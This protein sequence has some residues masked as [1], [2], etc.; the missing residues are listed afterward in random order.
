LTVING[1]VIDLSTLTL[2][3]HTLTVN[4]IDKA[5]NSATK[6]VT[7]NLVGIVPAIVDINPDTL[8]KASKGGAVTT[9]IEITGYDVN[10][11]DVSTVKLRTNKGIVSAQST[12]TSVGDYDSDGIPDRMVKFDRQAVIGIVDVGDVEVTISGKISGKDFEGTDVIRVIP[13]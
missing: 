12:P 3:Q 11:I 6:Y 4:G 1:Q 7:F 10:D 5:G 13:S 9:Y 8:N 2:G